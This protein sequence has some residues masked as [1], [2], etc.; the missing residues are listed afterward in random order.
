MTAQPNQ[1]L[2]RGLSVLSALAGA[3]GPVGSRDLARTLGEEHTRVSRL[4]GT[5]SALGLAEQDPDRRYRPG[6]GVHVLAAQCLRGSG[7]LS[8]ALPT[9]RKLFDEKR[10]AALGVVWR[11]H[12]CYLF[13]ARPG[14][15]FEEGLAGHP[16][17]PVRESSIGAVVVKGS[18]WATAPDPRAGGIGSVAVPIVRRRPTRH[19]VAGLALVGSFT[20]ASVP[21]AVRLLQPMAAEIE[22]KLE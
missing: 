18:K 5:L 21:S 12:V 19:P 16:L 15:S 1:S 4:L 17:F 3:D 13:Y 6:P 22:S 9:L 7:L 10:R 8:A 11:G 20:R 14:R 2:E